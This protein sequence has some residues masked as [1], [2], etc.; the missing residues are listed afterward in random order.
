M[1]PLYLHRELTKEKEEL[2]N[3]LLKVEEEL[4]KIEE[5]I[6]HRIMVNCDKC[7]GTGE[8]IYGHD[9]MLEPCKLCSG[10]GYISKRPYKDKIT[11]L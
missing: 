9:N 10:R 8:I 2:E 7:N 3:K 4:H 11:Y 5:E 1:D 6:G